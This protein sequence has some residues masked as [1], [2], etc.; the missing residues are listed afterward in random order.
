MAADLRRPSGRPLLIGALL[1]LAT[2]FFVWGAAAEH[3]GHSETSHAAT[4]S[5]SSGNGE[6]TAEH[7]NETT[8]GTSSEAQGESEYRPLGINLEST[9]VIVIAAVVS[10]LLAALVVWRP[11]KGPLLAV[12]VLSAA[13]AVVEIIEV[14]HQAD[15]NNTGLLIVALAACIT[16]TAV[17][18]LAGNELRAGHRADAPL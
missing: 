2:V 17:A 18:L 1:G 10:L 15:V 16:H 12:V 9:T 5:E 3:S 14:V 6:T 11:S 8:A 13:F 4:A 7:A